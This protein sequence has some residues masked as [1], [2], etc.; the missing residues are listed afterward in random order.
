MRISPTGREYAVFDITVDFDPTG[1]VYFV[2][3]DTRY[4]AAWVGPSV[5]ST[6][7]AGNPLQQ[8]SR[9]AQLFIAGPDVD[10]AT[11]GANPAG[12]IVLPPGRHIVSWLLADD[13]EL[14]E[15]PGTDAIDIG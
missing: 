12:T 11:L 4:Q 9:S 15:R 6:D 2:I 5:Q 14:V 8:W 13:P 7:A 3:D 1:A 10:E